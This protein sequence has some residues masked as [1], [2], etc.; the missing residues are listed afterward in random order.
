MSST[1]A[2][3]EARTKMAQERMSICQACPFA[4]AGGS[5]KYL[6]G[7]CGCVLAAKVMLPGASCPA[8]KW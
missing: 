3:S 4:I 5:R 2:S 7:K 8:G 1:A 6:C